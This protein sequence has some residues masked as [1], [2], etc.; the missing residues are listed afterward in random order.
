ME[1][2]SILI[3]IYDFGYFAG[4]RKNKTKIDAVNKARV[5]SKTIPSKAKYANPKNQS[6][7]YSSDESDAEEYPDSYFQVP[8]QVNYSLDFVPSD[9]KL[10]KQH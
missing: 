10:L 5:N 2:L 8:L 1:N 6:N 3:F 4:E 7:P 9:G